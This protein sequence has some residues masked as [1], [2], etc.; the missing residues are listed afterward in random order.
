MTA[1]LLEI[2]KTKEDT[3]LDFVNK[4]YKDHGLYMTDLHREW[5]LTLAWTRGHQNVNYDPLKRQ[6]V[7][8]EKNEWQSRLISNLLLPIVRSK[9]ARSTFT[10]CPW[11]VIPATPDQEDIDL[12]KTA[13]SVAEDIWIKNDLTTLLVHALT[14]RSIVGNAYIKVGFDPKAGEEV[15]ILKEDVDEAVLAEYLAEVGIITEQKTIKVRK[16]KIF[17]KVI[18]AFNIAFDPLVSQFSE[19]DWCIETNIRSKDWIVQNFG[20]KWK[21][22]I[23]ETTG[24]EVLIHPLTFTVDTHQNLAKKAGVITH[25]LFIRKCPM[26]KK[27]LYAFIADGKFMVKPKNLP[28]N[29]GKK[30]YIHIIEIYDPISALGT[31]SAIQT[32]PNQA[33]YNKILSTITDHIN[34]TSRVQWLIP[35]S[36]RVTSITNRPGE[37]IKFTGVN[38]PQQTKPQ[39]I[40]MY[41]ENTLERTRR[42]MQDTSSHHNVSQGQNEPGV[43]S[44]RQTLA[45]QDADESIEGPSNILLLERLKELGVLTLETLNQFVTEEEIIETVGEFNELKSVTYTGEMLKG[46]NKGNYFKIRMKTFGQQILSRAAREQ[47]VERFIGMGLL[48]PRADRSLILGMLGSADT[49]IIYD[50]ESVDRTRQWREITERMAK[51]EDVQVVYGENHKTHKETIKRF[52]ASSNRD[53]YEPEVIQKVQ[54]H[55]M[56]HMAME[57]AE[58]AQEIKI[59]QGAFNAGPSSGQGTSGGKQAGARSQRTGVNTSDARSGA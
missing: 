16:G 18:P 28:F 24:A 44:G 43:R 59:M 48:D 45:L 54:N 19:S 8:R 5:A 57:V 50:Q 31:S 26:F 1:N 2:T 6:W 49:E 14:W 9:V 27:G 3:V 12:A 7:R 51:G 13:T 17:H 39:S 11:E 52:M 4:A 32:R 20:M 56:Q 23:S 46:K 36:A 34:L 41:V 35:R 10:Q 38:P 37:N 47:Q 15:E 25:E 40:P 33:R 42:D 29:H 55:Y 58:V 53:K 22:K 30:P 21:D